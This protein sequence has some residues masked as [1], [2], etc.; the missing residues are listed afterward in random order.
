M[1]LNNEN[2]LIVNI[3]SGAFWESLF[4]LTVF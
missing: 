4:K 2:V 1:V 3:G